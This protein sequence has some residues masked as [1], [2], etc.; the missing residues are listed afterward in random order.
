[1]GL[2]VAAHSYLD[3]NKRVGNT[4][5]LQQ[6][7]E[8]L[9]NK[10]KPTDKIDTLT[11]SD[12]INEYIMLRLRLAAGIDLSD[13]DKRFCADF[14]TDYANAISWAKKNGLVTLVNETL[15]PTIKGFDLQNT[16]IAK[17]M[18]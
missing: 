15:R 18:K 12:I 11:S 7:F 4:D 16:L 13:F 6:Y 8:K 5:N 9:R 3:G 17:F 10:E 2:G 1:L 14:T